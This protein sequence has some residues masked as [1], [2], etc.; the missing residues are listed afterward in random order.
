VGVR[1]KIWESPGSSK[2]NIPIIL[3]Y[4]MSTLNNMLAFP[5]LRVLQWAPAAK[6]GSHVTVQ[7]THHSTRP[8]P[9]SS[10]PSPPPPIAIFSQFAK[11]FNDAEH[12][13]SIMG[14]PGQWRECALTDCAHLSFR[15]SIAIH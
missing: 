4:L 6:P 1:Q 5:A 15:P 14:S 2:V 12:A 11:G 9:A 10:Q 8:T 13:G 7:P 3:L